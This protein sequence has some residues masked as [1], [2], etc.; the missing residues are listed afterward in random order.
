M[1]KVACIGDS[2]TWGFTL[3]KP[4]KQSYPALLQ[5]KLGTEYKVGY[6][7]YNDASARFDA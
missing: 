1:T 6:F 2:I 3:L 5:E 4:W 7:G